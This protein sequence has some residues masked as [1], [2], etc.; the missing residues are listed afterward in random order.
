MQGPLRR[1]DLVVP[2]TTPVGELLPEMVA[3]G[4]GGRDGG[5][6]DAITPWRLSRA[7]GPDLE[8]DR[9]LRDE[10]VRDGD[11]LLLRHETAPSLGVLRSDPVVVLAGNVDRGPGRWTAERRTS[12]AI[13]LL[14]PTLLGLLAASDRVTAPGTTALVAV[15]AAAVLLGAA[16]ASRME[17]RTAVALAALAVLPGGAAGWAAAGSLE[18]SRPAA[19]AWT[20]GTALLACLVGSRCA[21][22]ARRPLIGFG[23]VLLAGLLLSTLALTGAGPDRVAAV[24][25]VVAVA[26]VPLVPHYALRVAGVVRTGA[27]T[28]AA[29]ETSAQRAQGARLV[30]TWVVG[31][32]APLVAVLAGVVAGDAGLCGR[33]LAAVAGLTLV[34][35][36]RS[37]LFTTEVVGLALAGAAAVVCAA[38]GWVLA[39]LSTASPAPA[40]LPLAGLCLVALLLAL[41][42]TRAA[43]AAPATDRRLRQLE[44]AGLLALVPLVLG[45]LGVFGAVADAASGLR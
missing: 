44:A 24:G 4:V 43:V 38:T 2:A 30:V 32:L 7:L 5:G 40:L 36:A 1:L 45:V 31:A 22:A 14:A 21:R 42:A 23:T 15:L 19:L 41:P 27:G 34:L 37:A 29:D 35:R 20:S 8:P 6:L 11:L 17:G 16:V 3:L 12:L 10:G 25:L 13:A 33:W 39:A 28:G 9:S 18:V 26:V